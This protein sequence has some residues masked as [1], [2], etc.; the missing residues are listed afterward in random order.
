MNYDKKLK[1]SLNAPRSKRVV[2]DN[3]KINPLTGKKIE[4]NQITSILEK[5]ITGDSGATSHL[6]KLNKAEIVN[7]T[8]RYLA[9]VVVTERQNKNIGSSDQHYKKSSIVENMRK[10][11]ESGG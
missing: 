9:N 3:R 2:S 1:K 7:T 8:S 11:N 10:I 5:I 4:E 6:K